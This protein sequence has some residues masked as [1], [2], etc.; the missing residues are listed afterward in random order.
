MAEQLGLQQALGNGA[1]IDRHEGAIA[2]RA[3]GV[4][5]FGSHL[6]A[7]AALAGDED[8]RLGTRDILDRIVHLQ[9]G[10]RFAD[11]AVIPACGVR[12]LGRLCLSRGSPPFGGVAHRGQQPFAGHGFDQEIVSTQPHRIDCAGKGAVGG[13]DDEGRERIIVR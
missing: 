12:A 2:A 9:H 13:H 5:R 1:A 11:E 7:R 6:L 3:C 10:R 8:R 4:D